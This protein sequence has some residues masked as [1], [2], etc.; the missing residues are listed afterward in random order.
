MSVPNPKTDHT[1]GPWHVEGQIRLLR[2]AL[3]R[4]M[5]ALDDWLNDFASSECDPKRVAEARKRI[6]ER[7]TIAYIARVQKQNRDAMERTK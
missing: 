6:M 5:V 4:S 1:P 7:G 2:R 3:K